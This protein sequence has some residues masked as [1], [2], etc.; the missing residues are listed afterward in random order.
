M[1]R[2]GK[3]ALRS[4]SPQ[5]SPKGRGRIAHRFSRCRE[6][7]LTGRTPAKKGKFACCS[8]SLGERVGVRAVVAHTFTL[9]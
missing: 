8:L 2:E 7:E 9:Q 6:P 3:M 5:P 1:M 4:P